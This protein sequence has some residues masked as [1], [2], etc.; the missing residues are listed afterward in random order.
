[1][2]RLIDPGFGDYVDRYTILQLKFEHGQPDSNAFAAEAECVATE[3]ECI[4][5]AVPW[6]D[7][8]LELVVK[9]AIVNTLLWVATDELDAAIARGSQG[10]ET[11]TPTR[12]QLATLAMRM[13]RLNRKRA[14]LVAELSGIDEACKEEIDDDSRE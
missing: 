12:H 14:S 3:A 2:G 8:R 11:T 10:S 4:G 13:R 5:H 6:I 9:I 1:M 7:M